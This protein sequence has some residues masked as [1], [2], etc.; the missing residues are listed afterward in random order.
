MIAW[1]W[2]ARRRAGRQLAA[3]K[4][5]SADRTCRDIYR[6]AAEGYHFAHDWIGVESC[7][8]SARAEV[9]RVV[10]EAQS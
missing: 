1:P 2:T 8:L 9:D 4:A 5:W 7:Y 10:S 3:M 6:I